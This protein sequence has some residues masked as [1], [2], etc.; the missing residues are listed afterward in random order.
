[1]VCRG[2]RDG[3]TETP[4]TEVKV[5]PETTY[6]GKSSIRDGTAH[7]DDWLVLFIIRFIGISFSTTT[8]IG[9]SYESNH[10][11]PRVMVVP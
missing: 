11:C 10:A 6:L 8:A 2:V 1:M 3:A 4:L 9:Y 5:V 7:I